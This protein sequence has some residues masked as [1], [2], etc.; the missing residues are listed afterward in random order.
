MS[1]E[2]LQI[3]LKSCDYFTRMVSRTLIV[4]T[5]PQTDS[6]YPEIGFFKAFC[7]V[8]FQGKSFVVEYA[9]GQLSKEKILPDVA[10]TVDFIKRTF[11][12]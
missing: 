10:K 2:N 3:Q 4:G 1:L 12:V 8:E 11:P 9:Q 5:D 6:N 7:S